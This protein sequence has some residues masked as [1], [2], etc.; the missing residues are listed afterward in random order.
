MPWKETCVM[1]EKMQFIVAYLE[2]EHSFAHLC[3]GFGISRKTGYKWVERYESGGAAGLS[4][5]SCA[6]KRHPNAVSEAIEKGVVACRR[7]HRYWGPRKLLAVLRRKEPEA[8]WPCASTVASILRRHG[9][10]VP[11]RRRRHCTPSASPL[12][13]CQEA[14][15]VWSADFKGWFRTQDQRRCDPLTICDGATRYLLRCQGL[16]G[17]TGFEAVAPLF[18]ATFREYGLPQALRTDNGPPFAGTG[19]GGLTR[20]N[21]WWL[22]LGIAVERIAPGKPQQ[23]GRHERMH[24]TL[25]AEAI[26][27]PARTLR[28]Q[29]KALD[30]FRTEYN[31]ER[32]HEALDDETPAS[33][34]APSERAYPARL[35]EAP[36]YPPDW[37]TRSVRKAGQMKWNGR[38]VL[39]SSALVGQRVG[40]EPLDDGLWRVYFLDT[41]LGLFDERAGTTRPE[42][43]PSKEVK[44]TT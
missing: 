2:H 13:T 21:V 6:P 38:D 36:A 34:Y 16:S 11:R 23:N 41:A 29:Q 1:D 18:E 37:A 39:V 9:L 10:S 14:N 19:L 27:P 26:N 31:Q 33:R 22:R 4:N 17:H 43:K 20:L 12:R 24:R 3:R 8:A 25:K 40:L 44:E 28:A 30:R 32:P 15:A 5:R 42:K 35:P 7:A